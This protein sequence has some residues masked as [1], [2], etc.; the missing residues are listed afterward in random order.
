MYQNFARAVPE[1]QRSCNPK[2]P[3]MCCNILGGV[4][5]WPRQTDT[6]PT[7]YDTRAIMNLNDG[8]KFKVSFCF[9]GFWGLGF[10]TSRKALSHKP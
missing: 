8:I 4:A 9:K 2:P 7:I 3:Q 5:A 10:R 6:T 1:M